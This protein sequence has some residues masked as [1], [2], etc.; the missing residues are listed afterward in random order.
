M[1]YIIYTNVNAGSSVMRVKDAIKTSDV[2]PVDHLR[3]V[4][5][6][7]LSFKVKKH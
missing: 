6:L 7:Q 2:G 3:A 5:H 1:I 4:G